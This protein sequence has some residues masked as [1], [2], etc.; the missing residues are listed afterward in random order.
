M[1]NDIDH[2]VLSR[3]A[4]AKALLDDELLQE[5]LRE[6]SHAA[7]R[8]FY[9]ATTPAELQRSKDLLESANHFARFLRSVAERGQAEV[10]KREREVSRDKRV[11][12]DP[13]LRGMAWRA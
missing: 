6:V 5:A 3:G 12:R 11:E 2:A 7:H 1:A 10:N 4:R 13:I 9:A 8:M